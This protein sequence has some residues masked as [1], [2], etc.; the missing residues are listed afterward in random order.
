MGGEF[1]QWERVEPRR[2]ASTGTCSTR[3]RTRRSQ[4]LVARPQPRLPRRAGAA[5][6]RLRARRASS[7]STRSDREASV[8]ELPA[9]RPRRRARSCASFNFT[10]VPRHELPGRRAARGQL[11]RDPQQRRHR[12]RRQR[13]G[14]P[15]RGRGAAGSDARPPIV[16]AADAAAALGRP[17]PPR[18]AV[19]LDL[20]LL[21]ATR[22]D[23]GLY[24]FRVWAP[25]AEHVE[26][27][28][29]GRDER[30]VPDGARAARLL[31]G[32]G[33]RR[34]RARATATAWTAGTSFPTRHRAGSPTA[35]T[36]R[37]RSST[38]PRSAWTDDAV[39]RAA[40]ARA[41]AVRAAHRH[42]HGRG[43]VRRRRSSAWTISSSSASPPA[44]SCRSPS[45]PASRNWGYDGVDLWAPQSTYGGPD[46][47]RRLVDACH[48][49]GLAVVLDVVYNHIGPEGNYLERFAPYMSD[50]YHTPWGQAVNVDGPGSD[51]V[52]RFF[53]GNAVH[54]LD[55]YH[56]DALR[57]D[58]IHGIVDTSAV[59]FWR[60]LS[61]VVAQLGEQPAPTAHADRGERPER[62]ARDASG[63]GR[64]PRTRLGV[65]RR[66]APRGARRAHRR[67][68]GLLRRLRHAR[69]PRQ[70]APP[71][72]RLR[73]ARVAV[74]RAAPRRSSR[75]P[76]RPPL[77][78]VLPEPRP[79]RQPGARRAAVGARGFR[80]GQARRRASCCSRRSC[81]C[82]SWARST[83]RRRR[84]CTSPT[85]RT[86]SSTR[87]C[88]RVGRA[89]SRRSRARG[90]CPTRRTPTPSLARASTGACA[91]RA[92]T[93]GCSTCTASCCA[94][95]ATLA[96]LAR[97]SL[98][99]ADVT[100]VED[101]ETIVLRRR[102][103]DDEVLAAF[104]V[105]DGDSPPDRAA[106]GRL[107]RRCCDS[108]DARFDGP[109]RAGRSA[110]TGWSSHHGRSSSSKGAPFDACLARRPLPP[111][112]DLGRR[113]RQLLDL[114]RARDRASS[115][116]CSTRTRTR[117]A[118]HRIRLTER[119]DLNWHCYLPDARPGQLYG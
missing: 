118:S 39:P 27:R 58:A 26:L 104:H 1:G 109:G 4:R 14:Q 8:A 44:R 102:A 33:A 36:G 65:V 113:G 48:A 105:G 43:H 52:R 103:G 30:F 111:G 80:D 71:G 62:R 46:G 72:L 66:P 74:P 112:C 24:N 98:R 15:R 106:R 97:L 2:R 32:D 35:S 100:L 64:R 95:A 6:A 78:R 96:P 60:E 11:A 93:G 53:C 45:S 67:A 16:R 91:S 84:S 116:A 37:R 49:R 75:G 50:R 17:V 21:G 68:R 5:R 19:I 38:R 41:R 85:T 20:D 40:A 99:D 59:P 87:P 55:E 22:L 82:C 117:R 47:L 28:L 101:A 89:S 114:L 94:C 70:G 34:W 56:V 12:L 69:R 3:R 57:L 73:R 77:R 108:A 79:D 13:P 119:T 110:A 92:S 115:S 7:G 31:H 9:A 63:N 88:A 23:E 42:V 76:R 54:W 83:A 86:R 90:S 10:P 25:R 81:P 29:F 107:A 51:E 18:G 61:E